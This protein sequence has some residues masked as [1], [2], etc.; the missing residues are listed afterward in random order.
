MQRAKLKFSEFFNEISSSNEDLSKEKIIRI[1][2]EIFN[3]KSL[4]ISY[5]E[6]LFTNLEFFIEDNSEEISSK[7][8]IWI[9]AINFLCEL[10]LLKPFQI[11]K[12]FALIEK[13]NFKLKE[14]EYST[15]ILTKNLNG[16]NYQNERDF[17]NNFSPI[18]SK[19]NY[20]EQYTIQN[21]FNWDK[22]QKKSIIFRE[23]SLIEKLE[24]SDFILKS[25]FQLFLEKYQFEENIKKIF[26][27]F[28]RTFHKK[29]TY[30][31]LMIEFNKV[32][33]EIMDNEIINEIFNN[34][35]NNINRFS[36]NFYS[37]QKPLKSTI[38]KFLNNYEE[39]EN[40][41]N[42]DHLDAELLK[43]IREFDLSEE[44]ESELFHK[45]NEFSLLLKGFFNYTLDNEFIYDGQI[46]NGKYNGKGKI[47][48]QKN[49][50]SKF[51]K[52]EGTFQ[53]DKLIFGTIYYDKNVTNNKLLKYE[54]QVSFEEGTGNYL[55]NGN[56]L[57]FFK[58][59]DVYEG[60]FLKGEFEGEGKIF[61]KNRS[62]FEGHFKNGLK[63]GHGYFYKENES[64]K[65]E[66]ISNQ[67]NG[68]GTETFFNGDKYEGNFSNGKRDGL[69]KIY[70]IF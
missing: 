61:Y 48:S 67:R 42:Y 58:N 37:E 45:C 46:Q 50:K 47:F 69:G 10:K 40:E 32:K 13:I 66:Y 4:K 26:E 17:Y 36:L 16:S 51:L 57:L 30:E 33:Y 29:L 20:N 18:S 31:N 14:K 25:P 12:L 23:E 7:N 44:K 52:I 41:V 19:N 39:H 63:E 53:N 34:F 1:F 22:T 8:Q 64:Y 38:N 3:Y 54:G 55:R 15:K 21:S 27:N 59:G 9:L 68:F 5:D 28:Q 2:H 6:N 11:K 35:I 70:N 24:F 56:G 60:N 49:N 43:I 65:G 62:I